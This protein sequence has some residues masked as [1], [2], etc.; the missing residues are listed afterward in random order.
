LTFDWSIID[1]LSCL[2]NL[3]AWSHISEHHTLLRKLSHTHALHELSNILKFSIGREICAYWILNSQLYLCIF[4]NCYFHCFISWLYMHVL[5]L[6]FGK[7]YFS[8]NFPP[9]WSIRTVLLLGP[10][11]CCLVVR[12]VKLRIWMQPWYVIVWSTLWKAGCTV[13]R[14]DCLSLRP[15]A[16]WRKSNLCR[17]RSSVAYI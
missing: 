11:V 3:V 9:V 7:K 8:T 10:N 6:L 15:N 12:M 5:K 14:L 13:V 2:E 4:L 16:S 17:F 1:F